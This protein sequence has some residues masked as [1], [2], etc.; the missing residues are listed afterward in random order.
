MTDD[1]KHWAVLNLA[2]PILTI[3]GGLGVYFLLFQFLVDPL[4][5]NLD[6]LGSPN[7]VFFW[8]TDAP[9]SLTEALAADLNARYAFA[10]PSVLMALVFVAVLIVAFGQV[11]PQFGWPAMA[12]GVAA[13]PLGAAIGYVEQYANPLRAAVADCLPASLDDS[14]P[15]DQAVAR[16]PGG[17]SFDAGVLDQIRFLVS[18]N[19]AV[20]VAGI[21]LIGICAIFIARTVPTSALDPDYLKRRRAGLDTMLVVVGL[22]LV[23]SVATTHGFYNF[24]SALMWP[25]TAGSFRLLASA[26]TT[27]WGAAYTTVLIVL[28]APAIASVARD[29]RRAARAALPDASFAQRQAW[30]HDQGIEIA[31]RERLRLATAALAPV[32]TAPVLDL[33]RSVAG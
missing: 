21:A 33:L 15:L 4:N 27:Y 5:P 16:N 11:L 8:E 6:S 23:F 19:S 3:I 10:I 17:W 9:A 32:L 26:G 12:L 13:L 30:C 18:V 2:L 25:E 1:D 7:A 29:A 22:L 31:L 14:C 20:S 24:S 28:A